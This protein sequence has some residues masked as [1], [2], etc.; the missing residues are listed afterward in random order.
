[1]RRLLLPGLF[2]L[3]GATACGVADRVQ[4]RGPTADPVAITDA[5]PASAR[6]GFSG[7]EPGGQRRHF[8]D[9]ELSPSPPALLAGALAARDHNGPTASA[10]GVAP[11][12]VLSDFS[13]EVFVPA[14]QLPGSSD[15][16][17]ASTTAGGVGAVVGYGV[18]AGI[19]TARSRKTI[20]VR[21]AG[22]IDGQPFGVRVDEEVRGRV[23]GRRVARLVRSALDQV[24][25][26]AGAPS[27]S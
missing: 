16:A 21:I 13:V 25:A 4:I 26:A 6:Q 7:A 24:A 22:S 18:V 14:V 27:G 12:V 19:E 11:A 2:L 17:T 23:T 3:L 5:R 20:T 8:G 9:A 10:V 15:V 1:M